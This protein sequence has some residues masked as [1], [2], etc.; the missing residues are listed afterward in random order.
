M[1]AHRSFAASEPPVSLNVILLMEYPLNNKNNQHGP[2]PYHCS[3]CG[4]D[5]GENFLTLNGGAL[6]YDE[7]LN[8][9]FPDSKGRAFLDITS[10][11]NDVP[12]GI[13]LISGLES[14]QYEFYFCSSTCI[15]NF[16]NKVVDDLEK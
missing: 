11:H 3:G 13:S 16:F 8:A 12:K 14:C 1:T 6:Y 10:H 9:Q 2:K 4:R 5:T 7:T 15:R